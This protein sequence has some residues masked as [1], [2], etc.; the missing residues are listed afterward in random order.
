M[1]TTSKAKRPLAAIL[2]VVIIVVAGLGVYFATQSQP[3]T[4]TASM[5]TAGSST[6]AGTATGL[7]DTLTIDDAFWP[8]GDLNQLNS[9]FAIPYP[10]WLTYTV[11][12]SLVTTNGTAQYT[13]GGV[14]ML[15]MLA[16]DWSASADGMTY[17]FNLRQNVTFSNG[18]P[19]NAYQV[20][21]Q[22]YGLYYLTGNSQGWLNSYPVFNMSTTNFEREHNYSDDPK[23]TN[24]PYA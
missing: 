11:Y 7:H 3:T 6:A 4:P 17:T 19:F 12:Q 1:S 10:D 16:T 22:M 20:W 21:G 18:D 9:V 15:P 24:Q 14:Q 13:T 2:I 23:R 8:S 5:T